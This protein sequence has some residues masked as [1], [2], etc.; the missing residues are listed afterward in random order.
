MIIDSYCGSFPKIPCV[1]RTSK[2]KTH[3]TTKLCCNGALVPR[4]KGRV[5]QCTS[6]AT[7]SASSPRKDQT[8]LL[9]RWS[10]NV[11]YKELCRPVKQQNHAKPCK[12]HSTFCVHPAL[13]STVLCQPWANCQV[14][15]PET[16]LSLGVSLSI[17][18]SWWW[19]GQ[20]QKIMY[21]C[22]GSKASHG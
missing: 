6:D 19:L 10:S 2:E 9:T 22:S 16:S 14:R 3:E 5:R 1:K 4:P 20:V 13:A 15:D 21:G 17:L 8:W 11:I 18:R 12:T 7:V